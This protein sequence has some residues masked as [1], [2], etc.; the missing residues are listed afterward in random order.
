M[1]YFMYYVW[2]DVDGIKWLTVTAAIVFSKPNFALYYP[3]HSPAKA[4]GM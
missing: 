4:N 1:H 3:S 2:K